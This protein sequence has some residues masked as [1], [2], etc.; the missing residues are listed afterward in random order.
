MLKDIFLIR[1]MDEFCIGGIR[2]KCPKNQRRKI[3]KDF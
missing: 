1:R 3:D 2:A